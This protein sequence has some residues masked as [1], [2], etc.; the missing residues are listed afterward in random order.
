[1]CIYLLEKSKNPKLSPKLDINLLK[2]PKN[3]IFPGYKQ[4]DIIRFPIFPGFWSANLIFGIDF[5]LGLGW[6]FT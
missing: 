6:K 4:I 3:T 5:A 2:I 1:M